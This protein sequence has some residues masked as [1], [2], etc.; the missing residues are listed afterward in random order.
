MRAAIAALFLV[1]ALG[2][3]AAVDG[4]RSLFK[5]APEGVATK[6]VLLEVV[7]TDRGTFTVGAQADSE[8]QRRPGVYATSRAVGQNEIYVLCDAT[9]DPQSLADSVGVDYRARVVKVILPESK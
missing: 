8:L 5:K 1:A 2:A 6:V 4:G 7:D 3:C 9:T